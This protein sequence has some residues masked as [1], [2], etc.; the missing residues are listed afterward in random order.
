MSRDHRASFRFTL[1]EGQDRALLRLGWQNLSVQILNVSATG[2]LL[3]CPQIDVC[4]DQ[5]LWLRTASAWTRVR[6][7][8]LKDA[9]AETHVGVERL[10]ELE[11]TPELSSGW[12]PFSWGP[13]SMLTGGGLGNLTIALCVLAGIIVGTL[14]LRYEWSGSPSGPPRHHVARSF[15]SFQHDL[16]RAWADVWTAAS[17]FIPRFHR[18]S[19]ESAGREPATSEP[20]NTKGTPGLQ[21]SSNANRSFPNQPASAATKSSAPGSPRAAPDNP[22]PK[23]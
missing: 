15:T 1:P 19:P 17:R 14:T 21:N 22:A 16:E 10:D 4:K 8:F 12:L 23:K 5:V 6:V 11:E 3:A 13:P 20:S 18:A 7:A 2:F 9:G